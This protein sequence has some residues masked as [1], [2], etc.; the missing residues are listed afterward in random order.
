LYGIA[1]LLNAIRF[2]VGRKRLERQQGT[3][4]DDGSATFELIEE[5]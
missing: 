5:N 2:Y 3:G 4:D 1:E